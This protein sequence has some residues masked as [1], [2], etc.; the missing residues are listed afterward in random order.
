VNKILSLIALI[1]QLFASDPA[2]VESG[3]YLHPLMSLSHGS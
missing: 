1:A 2:K 3:P